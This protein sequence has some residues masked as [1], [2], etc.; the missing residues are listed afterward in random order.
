MGHPVFLVIGG[1]NGAGKSTCSLNYLPEGMTYVNADEVAKTLPGYPSPA[2]DMQAARIALEMMDEFERSRD[3]FA[4]ETTLATRSLAGRIVR[5][6]SLGYEARL[7]FIWSP[8]AEFSVRRVAARVRSGGHHIPEATIRRRYQ[9][10]IDNFFRI[11]R[12]IVDAWDV[13]ENFTAGGPRL[14][15][16]GGIDRQGTVHLPGLW[17]LIQ[18]RGSR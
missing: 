5:L 8:S 2:V 14:I 4:V 10:G 16:E 15:A 6:R 7:V 1:P 12:P 11:Y 3:G 13:L 9:A 18:R 17:D